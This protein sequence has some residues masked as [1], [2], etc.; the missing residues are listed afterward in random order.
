VLS[1]NVPMPL[2]WLVALAC[3]S[4]SSLKKLHPLLTLSWYAA[5]TMASGGGAAL[6]CVS[7]GRPGSPSSSDDEGPAGE[8][9]TRVVPGRHI[10]GSESDE[11]VLL[12]HCCAAAH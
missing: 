1:W 3:P 2:P 7:A 4:M 5:P 8:Q 11:A 9:L 6:H 12:G 10:F